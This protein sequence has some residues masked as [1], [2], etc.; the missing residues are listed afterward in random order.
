MSNAPV[1]KLKPVL[2]FAAAEEFLDIMRQQSSSAAALHLDA[3]AVTTLTTP[4]IQIILAAIKSGSGLS[5]MSPSAEF[6][7]AF[8]DLGLTFPKN[9]PLEMPAFADAA[10]SNPARSEEHQ[11]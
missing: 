5:V 4:C 8:A 6:A 7:A 11:S 9:G 3:S 1:L 2:D 10:P